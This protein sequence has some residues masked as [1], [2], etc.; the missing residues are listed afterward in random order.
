MK[1]QEAFLA[2]VRG[3]LWETEVRLSKYEPID[4]SKVLSFAEEQSVV[5]L[6]T[7]GLGHVKDVKIPKEEVLQFVG[8]TL[9]LEQRNLE[10][11]RFIGLL[12]EKLREGGIYTLL[13]KGQGIAQCYEKPLWRSSGDI[14]L[15][16]SEDNYLKAKV[17][18]SK[19]ATRIDDEDS[20]SKHLCMTIEPWTVELHGT[21]HGG[22]TKRIDKELDQVQNSVF[23]GG[24]VRSWLNG[25]TQV[26]LPGFDIDI[27]FVFS[28]ILQH[29]FRGGIGLRQICDWCRLLYYYRDSVDIKLL[30]TRLKKMRIM[31]EWRV[32][33]V[34]TVDYLGMPQNTM[35]FYD[36]TIKYKNKALRIL[37]DILSN[38]NFGHNIDMSYRKNK[39]FL[40]KKIIAIYRYSV[41]SFKHAL[42]FPWNSI[43]IWWNLMTL[44]ARSTLRNL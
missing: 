29:F 26:F 8:K 37:L 9:Q 28:H 38:G 34:L 39:P 21:L 22:L 41:D 2:L 43:C 17:F 14:D 35:P 10:M 15:L 27:I 44:G 32:F 16:L 12:V 25:K 20:S 3:G 1:N 6:V 5:G 30:E 42:V 18:L 23:Y 7:A 31:S 40:I 36:C 24:Y 19:I 33:A 4:Y 11:N 13:V